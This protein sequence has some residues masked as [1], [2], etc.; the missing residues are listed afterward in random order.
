MIAKYIC[1]ICLNVNESDENGLCENCGADAW[2]EDIELLNI[3]ELIEGCQDLIYLA[4]DW[5]G[6]EYIDIPLSV[7]HNIEKTL[8]NMKR[9]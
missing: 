8:K 4:L 7:F 2:L 1:G 9:L 5:D 3:E 6:S